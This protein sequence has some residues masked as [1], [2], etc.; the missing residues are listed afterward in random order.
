MIK[1]TK[2]DFKLK[3]PHQPDLSESGFVWLINKP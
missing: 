2:I 1:K 3:L